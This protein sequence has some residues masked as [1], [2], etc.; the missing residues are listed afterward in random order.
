MYI[1]HIFQNLLRSYV[2]SPLHLEIYTSIGVHKGIRKHI[3]I[4]QY[5]SL[6]SFPLSKLSFF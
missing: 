6:S 5:T 1:L 3:Y 4:N 2:H